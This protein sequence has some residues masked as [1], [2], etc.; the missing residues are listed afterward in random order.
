M[1]LGIGLPTWLGNV[2]SGGDVL[3]WARF[4]DEAGFAALAVHDRPFHDTWEPMAA[5][6]AVAPVTSRVRLLTGA[7]LLPMRD[8]ALV[9]KQASVLDQVSEGRLDLGMALGSRPEDF[10]L[11]GRTTTGRGRIFEGQLQRLI[12]LWADAAASRE[13]GQVAGPASLQQPHPPFWVGGYTPAA[14]ERAATYGQAYLF[15]APGVDMIR[16]RVPAIRA[17]ATAAGKTEFPV[18]ALAYV[19]PATDQAD[20]EEGER[21]LLRYY[22][23][24]RKPFPELV[25]TGTND[26]VV[27][28]L[29]AYQ[30]AGVD[31]LNVILLTTDR[32]VLERFARDVLPR[33]AA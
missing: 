27:A 14:I 26:D 2:V 13:S 11:F 23:T 1:R 21:L 6:L 28:A 18:G 5:L 33:Y 17:A 4:A 16:E 24:L 32:G 8:E 22:G 7:L 20:L 31:L 19:L 12:G 30:D 3:D 9:F 10:G 25:H 15:G 29:D